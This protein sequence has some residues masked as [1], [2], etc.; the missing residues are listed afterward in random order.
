M[1]YGPE[2]TKEICGYLE[3]GSNRTD[4]C[5]LAGINFD[6]F[7]DWFKKFP[8]FSEAIKKAEVKFKQFNVMMVLKASEKSWQAAAWMLER[9]FHE[10][11]A[12]KARDWKSPNERETPADNQPT[13]QL[14]TVV[15]PNGNI[16]QRTGS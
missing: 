2:I 5:I 9:K 1:K 7:R 15:N 3:T 10:E 12:L 16:N 13:H 4:S 11:F 8:E 14:L 6:T